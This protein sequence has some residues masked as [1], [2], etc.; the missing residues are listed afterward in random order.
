M[1]TEIG[2]LL[3]AA[4]ERT[5]P[6]VRGIRDEQLGEPTPCT[7][8]RVRDLLN[9]LFQVVVSMQAAARREQL[10][11]STTPDFLTE[12]WRD[13]FAAETGNLVAAW[14]DPVALEG[15][16]PGM[17]LPQS[18]VGHLALADL[19]IHG[20]DLATATGRPY[21]PDDGAV[22]AL[23]PFMEQMAPTGRKMGAFRDEVVEAPAGAAD[24]ERLLAF[25]GRTAQ[26]SI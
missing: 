5:V 13:R 3:A 14:S 2:A 9:H 20:W 16:S 8:F 11:F 12:G 23:L 1:T 21:A 19:T 24:F 6:I 25:S 7:E 17:G 18:L 15:V 22:E 4:A 10:D 26:G